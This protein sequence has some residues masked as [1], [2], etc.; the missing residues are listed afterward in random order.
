ME[1]TEI[2]KT[3]FVFIFSFAFVLA[4]A[5]MTTRMVVI[6]NVKKFK[7]KN[8]KLIEGI[9]I[10]PQKSLQLVKIANKVVMI[11]VSKDSISKIDTFDINDIV[12]NEEEI[13]NFNF[14]E[15]V[16]KK[17]M[18][19]DLINDA[20]KTEEKAKEKNIINNKKKNK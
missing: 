13:K 2:L 6:A 19:K 12:Y 8:M 9:S 7:T 10:G 4:L 18:D 14:F 20:S 16:L 11:A 15:N 1:G 17:E 3:V 5:Y